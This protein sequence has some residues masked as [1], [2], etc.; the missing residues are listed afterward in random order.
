MQTNHVE[1]LDPALV[2]PGRID[3]KI[4]Y[5]LASHMQ[6]LAL[7]E[8]FFPAAKFEH[9]L[10]EEKA[11]CTVLD[12]AARFAEAVP[13][14][15]FSTAELQ[16]FLLSHKKNP[17]SAIQR[18]PGWVESERKE[19]REREASE[20][21]RKERIR[22]ARANQMKMQQVLPISP[23]PFEASET[24]SAAGRSSS[25]FDGSEDHHTLVGGIELG[26]ALDSSKGVSQAK[27]QEIAGSDVVSSQFMA[28]AT[29]AVKGFKSQGTQE[30]RINVSGDTAEDLSSQVAEDIK[31]VYA[32]D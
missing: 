32:T 6:A 7:F 25:D 31:S 30:G 24:M 26:A 29:D 21:K 20:K 5:K 4:E 10:D 22:L 28:D 1:Q 9:L 18:L 11:P 13:E 27:G 14:N 12:L 2:R 8:H 23:V 15:E 3:V 19:K 16:G 17:V